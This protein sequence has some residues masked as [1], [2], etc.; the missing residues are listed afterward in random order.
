[1][2]PEGEETQISAPEPATITS[3]NGNGG[4]YGG[5]GGGGISGIGGIRTKTETKTKTDD[6]MEKD[7]RTIYTS[8]E[9]LYVCAGHY[10]LCLVFR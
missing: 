6:D 2:L 1:M 8:L 9:C 4:T 5:I 10:G 3:G 7:K